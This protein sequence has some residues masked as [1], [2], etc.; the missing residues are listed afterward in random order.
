MG[1][2]NGKPILIE[3][4]KRLLAQNSGLTED[5]VE[6]KFQAFLKEHP[7]GKLKKSD[8]RTMMSQVMFSSDF[9]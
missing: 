6:E 4:D 5:Q 3:E 2:K 8:F 9:Q 1:C 7:S